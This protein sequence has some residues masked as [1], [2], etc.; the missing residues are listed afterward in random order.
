MS[1]AEFIIMSKLGGLTKTA[2]LL[3]TPEKSVAVSTVQGW[4]ERGKIP[5]EWWMPIIEAAQATGTEI[6]LEMFLA[7][8]EQ[9]GAA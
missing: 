1:P 9:A 4:K 2:N 6:K 5:Q 3:S 7:V 8:P